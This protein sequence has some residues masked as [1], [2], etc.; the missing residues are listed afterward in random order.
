MVRSASATS[1][2]LDNLMDAAAYEAS[3]TSREHA[4][5]SRYTSA[6]DDDRR[7]M[8]ARSAPAGRG[9]V[10]RRAGGRAARAPARPSAGHARAGGLRLSPRP[11]ARNTSAE[12]ELSFLGGGHLRPLR[13]GGRRLDHLAVGVPHALHALPAGDL[14]GQPAGDVRV[15]DGDLR[16]HR[17]AG[18]QRL[19]LRRPQRARSRRLP[20]QA[21]A[22]AAHALPRQPR[23][24]SAQP[25]D[26]RDHERRLGHDD[27]G[28][29]AARRRDRRRPPCAGAV[30]DDV[31]AVFLQHPNFFGASRMSRRWCRPPRRRARWS[32]SSATRSASASCARP[33]SSAPTS[34]SPRASRSATRSTSA[35]R[36]SASSPRRSATCAAC[37]AGSW[38]R[39]STSTGAAAACSRCRRAS[40]TSAARRPRTTSAPT[41]RCS[42]SRG[43]IYLAGSAR[44][45]GRDRRAAAA[46]H[47]VRAR[48]AGRARRRRA[49]ARA[50]RRS[51]VRR[52]LDADAERGDRAAAPPTASIRAARSGG[53]Y[54]E[55]PDGLLVAVTEKRTRA[56]IDGLA[57]TLQVASARARAR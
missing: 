38:A 10:R 35:A 13:P 12:D 8:L 24:A 50:A 48:G 32:S 18:L 2:E 52:P 45:A 4:A 7:A 21:A 55:H 36:A 14:A 54:P 28:A 53:G 23:R 51:G 47:R 6:T 1:G 41:R 26:A 57:R 39:R 22:A 33:A 31:S 27:R 29:P 30:D 5:V 17:P 19:A 20:R 43:V 3:L 40:S 16:A 37:R 25:R 11:A 49:A 44:G 56:E 42:R 9:A 15:P 34:P 46:A